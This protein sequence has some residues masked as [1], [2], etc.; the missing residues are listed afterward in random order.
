MHILF[1]S[2]C[3]HIIMYTH[4]IMEFKRHLTVAFR[5]YL[6]NVNGFV[7]TC[8]LKRFTLVF[9]ICF[10][11]CYMHVLFCRVSQYIC[12]HTQCFRVF[13]AVT[14]L[15]STQVCVIKIFLCAHVVYT[16][17]FF[18]LCL[19]LFDYVNI[20]NNIGVLSV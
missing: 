1:S 9:H 16:V 3:I 2:L 17:F 14:S 12:I 20:L 13:K 11:C 18:L 7:C 5:S 4:N 15:L 10:D 6:F 19:Y 8:R